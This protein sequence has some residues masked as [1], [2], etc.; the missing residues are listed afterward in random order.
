MD[1][2]RLI[3]DRDRSREISVGECADLFRDHGKAL[4]PHRHHLVR[5]VRAI[6]ELVVP[7]P[8]RLLAVGGEE[9][10]EPRLQVAA[11]VANDHRRRVPIRRDD[12]IEAGFVQL[13]EGFLRGD[14]IALVLVQKVLHDGICGH[15][16]NS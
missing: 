2:Q 12:A 14:A 4:A 10:G 7:L 8:P 16:F 1:R 3:A 6:A 5:R 15:R 11:D 13:L 9:V